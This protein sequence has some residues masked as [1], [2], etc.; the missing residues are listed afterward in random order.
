MNI[1]ELWDNT[2]E[3]F[4]QAVAQIVEGVARIFSPNDDEYPSVGLQ[5]F[6]GDPYQE[7]STPEW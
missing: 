6:D 1:K 4:S 3:L 5:P 7:T 2:S